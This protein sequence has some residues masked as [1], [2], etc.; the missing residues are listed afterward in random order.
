MQRDHPGWVKRQLETRDTEP[1]A[2]PARPDGQ[3]RGHSTFVFEGAEFEG[4]LRLRESFRIDSEFRGEIVSEG[5][6]TVGET[7]GVEANI[8]AREV[9][10][11]GAVVGAVSASRQLIIR[12][13]GRLHGDVV[14]PCLEVERGAVFNGRMTMV[15]PEVA[16]RAGASARP[17]IERPSV[18]AGPEVSI[19]AEHS[20]R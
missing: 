15:R 14:T 8:S 12:S 13:T 20:T 4:T 7:A 11:S 5:T 10:I 1:A 9:I 3:A 2:Q 19:S 17:R 18:H 16:A 6:V